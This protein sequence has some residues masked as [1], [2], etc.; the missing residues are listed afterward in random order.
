MENTPLAISQL[1][2]LSS[3]VTASSQTRVFENYIEQFLLVQRLNRVKNSLNSGE[4]L[5]SKF[6]LER[7]RAKLLNLIRNNTVLNQHFGLGIND[8]TCTFKHQGPNGKI[9]ICLVHNPKFLASP[10][11]LLR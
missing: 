2:D 5:H 7:R 9:K 4:F 10:N 1:R 11:S 3:Y 8:N 6:V